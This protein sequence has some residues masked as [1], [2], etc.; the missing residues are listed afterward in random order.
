MKQGLGTPELF[1]IAFVAIVFCTGCVVVY[2][3][4]RGGTRK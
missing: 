4:M 1:I 3:F 2:R